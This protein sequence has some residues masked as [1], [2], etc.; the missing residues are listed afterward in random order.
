MTP[1]DRDLIKALE[2]E[3]TR[4]IDDPARSRL[5]WAHD[6]IKALADQ[7]RRAL[8]ALAALVP[9]MEA[10]YLDLAAR[11]QKIEADPLYAAHR[12]QCEQIHNLHK[13]LL[14]EYIP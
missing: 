12:L 10:A 5:S 8:A 2:F 13:E 7:Q 3:L 14:K 11:S 1:N 9:G 4:P 6:R